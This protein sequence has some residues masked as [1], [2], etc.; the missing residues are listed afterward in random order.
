MAAYIAVNVLMSVI[1][2]LTNPLLL[3]VE[4]VMACIPL[5]AFTTNYFYNR[6]I[7]LSQPCKP[8]LRDWIRVNAYV[9]IVFSVIMFFGCLMLLAVLNNT[10]MMQ[11]LKAQ[12]AETAPTG[13]PEGQLAR[14]LKI[15]VYIFLPFSIL[16]FTHIIITLRLLKQYHW[17]FDSPAD[18][19]Q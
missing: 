9:S 5:Y 17:V 8:S 10:E 18:D 3:L 1:V 13:V 11:Q 15:S 14:Y 12:L 4:F 19:S 7:K 16:L 2:S 6:G